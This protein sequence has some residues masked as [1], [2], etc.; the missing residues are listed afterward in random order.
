MQTV[1]RYLERTEAEVAVA[2]LRAEGVPVHLADEEMTR[3]AW[4]YSIALGGTRLM[5]PDDRLEEARALLTD[6]SS[7]DA[8]APQPGAVDVTVDETCPACKSEAVSY[9]GR[10]RRLRAVSMLFIWFGVPVMMWGKRLRCQ[11]CGYEWR[12]SPTANNGS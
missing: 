1:A 11:Q 12:R 4:L 7:Q 10:D 3:L 9:S 6:L 2:L 5:V 8:D